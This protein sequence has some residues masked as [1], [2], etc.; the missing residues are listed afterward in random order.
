MATGRTRLWPTVRPWNVAPLRVLDKLQFE[1]N[2]VSVDDRGELVWLTR[3][4][5]RAAR[6]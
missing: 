4:L 5:A 1:Q 3:H 6:S 2:H